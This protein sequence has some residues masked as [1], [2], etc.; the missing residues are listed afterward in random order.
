M[1]LETLILLLPVWAMID[2]LILIIFKQQPA[3]MAA[4]GSETAIQLNL[5]LV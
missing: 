4:K 2:K 1:Q 5:D 3:A